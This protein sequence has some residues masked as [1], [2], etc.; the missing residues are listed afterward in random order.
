[1]N[2]YFVIGLNWSPTPPPKSLIEFSK[3]RLC[4]KYMMASPNCKE[5]K[6]KLGSVMD[7]REPEI[8]VDTQERFCTAPNKEAKNRSG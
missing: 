1:M 4:H 5:L 6:R 8:W 2:T 3:P 7:V